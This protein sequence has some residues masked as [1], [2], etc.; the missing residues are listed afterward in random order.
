MHTTHLTA[1]KCCRIKV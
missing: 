1:N